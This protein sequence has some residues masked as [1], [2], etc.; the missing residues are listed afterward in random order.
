MLNDVNAYKDAFSLSNS[1]WDTVSTW[2]NFA[3][4]TIGKQYVRAIDSISANIAEG[5]GMHSKKDK[6]RFYRYARA[7]AYECLDWTQKAKTRGLLSETE[8]EA[9]FE[10]LKNLPKLINTHIKFTENNYKE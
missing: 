7:S 6:I 3:K 1:V 8:Y 9:I 10:T 5:Y 4:D 2:D